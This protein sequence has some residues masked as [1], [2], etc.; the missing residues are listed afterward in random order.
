[1]RTGWNTHGPVTPGH[2]PSLY[3]SGR[4]RSWGLWRLC[5]N[6]EK[7][8]L[9]LGG[10]SLAD[11]W[12]GRQRTGWRSD[13]LAQGTSRTTHTE[14]W[15]W[16]LAR[17][18]G[19]ARCGVHVSAFPNSRK[20][21]GLWV[22]EA[23]TLFPGGVVEWGRLRQK[24]HNSRVG[25]GGAQGSESREKVTDSSPECPSLPAQPAGAGIPVSPLT[26]ARDSR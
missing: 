16:G 14:P 21:R 23:V 1:M 7:V 19:S 22:E 10:L 15:V 24:P 17:S 11:S 9:I 6:W 4:T 25:G 3:W 8:S 20:R 18:P 5:T 12:P 2:P 13:L 26:F